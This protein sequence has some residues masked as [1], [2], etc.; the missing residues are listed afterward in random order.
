MKYVNSGNGKMPL[1]SLLAILSIS[2]TVN[3]PGLAISPIEGKLHDVFSH[4][5]DLQIQLLEVLPNVVVIPFILLAGKIATKRRQI[6]VLAFGLGLYALSGV[7]YLFANSINQLIVLGCILGVGCGLVIPLAAS[8][9]SEYFEGEA[10][11][12]V[13]GKKSGLSNFMVIIGTALVGWIAEFDWHYSFFIYLTPLIPLALLPFMSNRFINTHQKIADTP[14]P[15]AQ[16]KTPQKAAAGSIISTKTIFWAMAG[17]IG[18]YVAMTYGTM[19]VSYYIPFTMQHFRF[20]SGQVGVATAMY[21]LAATVAGFLLPY[22]VKILGKASLQTAIFLMAIGLYAVAI[23]HTDISYCIAIFVT[24]FGYGILQ[25]VI[26]D[27]TTRV[28]PN[29]AASTRYF[30]YLLSGNYVGIAITPFIIDAM[31]KLFHAT[32]DIEF[33]YIFNGSFTVAVLILSI[34]FCRSFVFNANRHS[35]QD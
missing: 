23:F 17:L 6:G 21:Y 30:S 27:K 24:G 32:K 34:I 4:V 8:L 26:Y 29:K 28:A 3:L 5:S 10:R 13:L 12:S 20:D 33:S 15:A 14:Q 18:L 2:L 16:A 19:V 31:S 1:I 35:L 7:A 25:P 9:I 11:A 22:I